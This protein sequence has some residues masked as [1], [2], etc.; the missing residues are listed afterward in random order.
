MKRVVDEEAGDE[1]ENIHDLLLLER[2]YLCRNSED[3]IPPSDTAGY[4]DDSD[5]ED[6][7]PTA[8]DHD[9]YF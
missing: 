2:L 3:D 1:V 4:V 7:D 8:P 9:D 5:D 6:Y